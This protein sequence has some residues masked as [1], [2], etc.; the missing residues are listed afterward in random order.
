MSL[1][2]LEMLELVLAMF[3][4]INSTLLKSLQKFVSHK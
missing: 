3:K 1:N 2:G 4:K